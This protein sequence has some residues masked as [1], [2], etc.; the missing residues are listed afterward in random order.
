MDEA[1][2]EEAKKEEAKK[3]EGKKGEAKKQEVPKEAVCKSIGFFTGEDTSK[4]K[5]VVQNTSGICSYIE[6]SCCSADDFKAI[7]NWWEGASG[8]AKSNQKKRLTAGEDIALF[9]TALIKLAPESE[10][11]VDIK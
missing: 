5:K 11:A 6:N 7:K 9:T 10:L 4:P 2:K 1:K 3:E 8:G